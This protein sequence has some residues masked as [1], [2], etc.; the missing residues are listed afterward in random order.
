M[1]SG[2]EVRVLVRA[3][4]GASARYDPKAQYSADAVR[5]ICTEAHY[6][7]GVA[8]AYGIGVAR[9]EG[10][11]A[12]HYRL[13]ALGAV[14][15]PARRKALA[16]VGTVVLTEKCRSRFAAWRAKGEAFRVE[17]YERVE[18]RLVTRLGEAVVRKS[19]GARPAP[20]GPSDLSYDRGLGYIELVCV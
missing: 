16:V 1:F 5:A 2:L 17:R 13:A 20:Y 11:A 3:I 18:G 15:T 12:E 14:D 4:T 7:R 8:Y 10:R 9:D 19:S 6:E